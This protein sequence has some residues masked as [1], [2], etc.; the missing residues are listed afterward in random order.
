MLD[1]LASDHTLAAELLERT[2]STVRV[3]E[4]VRL[5]LAPAFLLAGIGAIMNVMMTRLIWVAERI[6]RLEVRMEEE[7][8]LREEKELDW[9]RNRRKLA[10][11][12]V[13]FSTSA[14]LTISIVIVLL[15]VSAF[16]TPQIGSLTAVAWILTMLLLSTGLMLFARETIVA[17]RG[18]RKVEEIEER[19]G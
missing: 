8:T 10:Q 4:I 9:L 18:H 7:H 11:R 5:S 17:A 3:Q 6:E 15:F 1:L 19:E 16:I 14:A 13:M 12:A 2:A